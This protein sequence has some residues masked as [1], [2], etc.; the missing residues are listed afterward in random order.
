MLMD[1]IFLELVPCYGDSSGLVLVFIDEEESEA[2]SR[3]P[4]LS[5]TTSHNNAW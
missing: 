4:K 2:L 1:F 5:A 3:G